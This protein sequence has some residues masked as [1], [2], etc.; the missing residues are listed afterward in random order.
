[1]KKI[2]LKKKEL[3]K[4]NESY[5]IPV[6]KSFINNAYIKPDQEYDFEINFEESKEN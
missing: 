1:M 3:K 2:I 5:Y 6:D 4:T